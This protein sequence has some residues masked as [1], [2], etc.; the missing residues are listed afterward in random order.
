MTSWSAWWV[1]SS[2][3]EGV[4]Q[5]SIAWA[6]KIEAKTEIEHSVD[7]AYSLPVNMSKAK[8]LINVIVHTL[9]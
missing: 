4:K 2:D 7:S 5:T 1:L 8:I 9:K 3:S 6:S